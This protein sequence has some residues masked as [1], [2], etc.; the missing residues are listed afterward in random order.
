MSHEARGGTR[1]RFTPE[2]IEMIEGC[3]GRPSADRIERAIEGIEQQVALEDLVILVISSA[4]QAA[5]CFLDFL[6]ELNAARPGTEDDVLSE[7]ES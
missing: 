2:E 1:E 5:C 3:L 7:E 6:A 4:G